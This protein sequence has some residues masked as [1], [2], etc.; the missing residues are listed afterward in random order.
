MKVLKV[1]NEIQ[2]LLVK[3]LLKEYIASLPLYL[4]SSDLKKELDYFDREYNTIHLECAVPFGFMLL[5]LHDNKT[6]AACIALKKINAEICELKRLYVKPRFRKNGLGRILCMTAIEKAVKMGYKKMV[7]ET[8]STMV[9]AIALYK[10]IGFR[11]YK[12]STLHRIHDTL[13]M[14]LAWTNEQEIKK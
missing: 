7:L 1:E 8:C 12:Q 2:F 4:N 14:E 11:E 3:S 10:S 5:A 9:E 13:H 6:A